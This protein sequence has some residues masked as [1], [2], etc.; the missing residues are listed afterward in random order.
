MKY[1]L[2]TLYFAAQEADAKI[3]LFGHTHTPYNEYVNGIYILNPGS[4]KG[5]YGTYGTI[6]ISKSG[7]VTNI[8]QIN[9]LH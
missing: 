7:I 9:K 8:I 5:Y 6:D 1:D 2:N 3:V 4:I